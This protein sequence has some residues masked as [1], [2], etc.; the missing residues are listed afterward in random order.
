MDAKQ[1]DEI[2]A[3]KIKGGLSE[4]GQKALLCLLRAEF[5]DPSDDYEGLWED[6]FG[7]RWE[8]PRCCQLVLPSFECWSCED[9]VA[10]R[11]SAPAPAPQRQADRLEAG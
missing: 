3:A 9:W 6:I 5:D 8:C 4:E 7:R 2:V 1:W 10:P 11:V